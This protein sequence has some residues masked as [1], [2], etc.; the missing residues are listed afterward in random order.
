MEIR[1]TSRFKK[2]LKRTL[3]GRKG[4]GVEKV[5]KEVVMPALITGE[6]LGEKY[7]DHALVGDWI[8]AR[9]C[10]VFPDTLLIYRLDGNY[11]ILVRIGSHAE[12]FG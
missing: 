5:L 9:E 6:P 7:R 1:Q 3:K 11:L 2:D 4:P 12:L 10:H 8:P